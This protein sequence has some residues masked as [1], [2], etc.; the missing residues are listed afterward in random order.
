[1]KKILGILFFAGFSIATAAQAITTN[2]QVAANPP[3]TLIDWPL[4]KEVLTYVAV[5]Q[6]T[7]RP[8]IIKADLHLSDGTP[9]ATTNLAAATVRTIGRNAS[10]VMNAADVLPLEK[11]NFTGRFKTILARTGKLPAGMYEL[12]IQLVNPGDFVPVSESRCRT[13]TIAAV[14]LPVMMMPADQSILDLEKAQ[15]AITFRWTPAAPAPK[16]ILTYRVTVFEVLEG[17]QPMQAF[18]ANQPLLVKDVIG[19]TQL[20]WQPQLGITYCCNDS[21]TLRTKS[22]STRQ[23]GDPHEHVNSS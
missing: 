11:M 8:F 10:L 22:D 9:V 14:Q 17:Q 4:K 19:S 3:A 12:C 15:T 20:I 1:M 13:F 6:G 2:L 18:R 16:E 21:M 7:E 23:W 5:N